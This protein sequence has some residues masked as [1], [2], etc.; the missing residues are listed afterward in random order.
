[1]GVLQYAKYIRYIYVIAGLRLGI[2]T[3]RFILISETKEEEN[4]FFQLF[5]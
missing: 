2:S 3:L 1:M 5:N 4:G